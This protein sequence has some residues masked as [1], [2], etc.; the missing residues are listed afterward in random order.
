MTQARDWAV[1][2]ER[3]LNASACSGDMNGIFQRP[4]YSSWSRSTATSSWCVGNPRRSLTSRELLSSGTP[5]LRWSQGAR[6][7]PPRLLSRVVF[8]PPEFSLSASGGR[9]L[10]SPRVDG[11]LRRR[12]GLRS[13]QGRRR[14]RCNTSARCCSGWKPYACCSRRCRRNALCSHDT[15]EV[16]GQSTFESIP[17]EA[18]V[19]APR[20]VPVPLFCPHT[21]LSVSSGWEHYKSSIP[22]CAAGRCLSTVL[23]LPGTKGPNRRFVAH[24][25]KRAPVRSMAVCSPSVARS[26]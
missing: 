1:F 15:R 23:M 18:M 21:A 19:E 13:P 9:V 24:E 25:W 11:G 10:A 7:D 16:S 22:L 14:D 6:P 26:G 2:P 17:A 12:P 8:P 3:S 4:A 20:V 5:F